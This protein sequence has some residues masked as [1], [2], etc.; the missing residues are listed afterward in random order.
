MMREGKGRA[1]A[2]RGDSGHCTVVLSLQ[3]VAE[4][5]LETLGTSEWGQSAAQLQWSGG[6]Q[7]RGKEV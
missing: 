5:L 1:E 3:H 2:S 7:P 4:A 6:G